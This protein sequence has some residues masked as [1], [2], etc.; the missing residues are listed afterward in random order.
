V[1]ARPGCEHGSGRGVLQYVVEGC[2]A[3][4]GSFRRIKQRYELTGAYFQAFH[5]LTPH[6]SSPG[7]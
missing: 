6:S 1:F 3:W 4:F 2:M 5:G 7:N